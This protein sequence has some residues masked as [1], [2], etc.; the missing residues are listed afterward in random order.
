MPKQINLLK[1]QDKAKPYTTKSSNNKNDGFLSIVTQPTG[2]VNLYKTKVKECK[3]KKLLRKLRF[4]K[5]NKTKL[6]EKRHCTRV[7]RFNPFKK[8]KDMFLPRSE[9]RVNKAFNINVADYGATTSH[10]DVFR[11]V[12]YELIPSIEELKNQV[13]NISGYIITDLPKMTFAN[14]MTEW[15]VKDHTKTKYKI[16][17]D[18][19]PNVA[20]KSYSIKSSKFYNIV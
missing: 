1:K 14:S 18:A 19:Y 6:K 12:K 7:Q 2:I 4:H 15:N 17:A 11:P 8:L 16:L 5:K 3:L 13:P 10:T 20:T 9:D